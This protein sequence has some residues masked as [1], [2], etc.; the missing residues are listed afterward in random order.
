[1]SSPE[2]TASEKSSKMS[3]LDAL[4][5][6]TEQEGIHVALRCWGVHHVALCAGGPGG[7]IVIS[8]FSDE[9]RELAAG[10]LINTLH[11]LGIEVSR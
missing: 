6:W 8:R 11:Y 5:A 3:N 10:Y 4:K 9:S 1:M 7:T 2:K